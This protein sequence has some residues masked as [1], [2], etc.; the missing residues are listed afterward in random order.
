MAKIIYGIQ[1]DGLGHYSRSKVVIDH[2]LAQGHQ[3]KILT[4]ERVYEL[5]KDEYDVEKIARISFVYRSNRVNYTRTIYKNFVLF[6]SIIKDGLRKAS[7]VFKEFAPDL[8][9]TDFEYFSAKIAS[10]RKVPILCI[11]NIHSISRTDAPKHVKRKY[12]MYE[13]E[14]VSLVKIL[15]P[16]SRSMKHYFIVSF[17]NPRPIRAKTTI[18]PPLIREEIIDKKD[19]VE[20]DHIF[21]YQTSKTNKRLFP[22]LKE[23]NKEKFIIYGFDE[24]KKEENLIFRKT[25]AGGQFLKDLSTAKAVITNGGFSLMSEAVFLKKPILS[26]PVSGQFEQIMNAT[27]LEREG[28][29]AFSKRITPEAIKLFLRNLE[30]Y[31]KNLAGFD[32]E[33]N[34]CALAEID[35]KIEEILNSA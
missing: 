27:M 8:V 9:I 18:I 25:R 23:V 22:A 26:N 14:Q 3:V 29:G 35:S 34:S 32:H 33:D 28:Y 1:S 13:K 17:F 10:K 11:D 21:V 20:K 12:M 4:S 15:S 19:E 30:K 2:L 31:R 24:E 6:P 7:Y 5:M 16:R